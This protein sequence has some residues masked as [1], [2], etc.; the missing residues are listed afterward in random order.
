MADKIIKLVENDL[1]MQDFEAS[2]GEFPAEL[3]EPNKPQKIT[4]NTPIT[5]DSLIELG[6]TRI[7]EYVFVK[8]LL[9]IEIFNGDGAV[10]F[11]GIVINTIQESSVEHIKNILN[12]QTMP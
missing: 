9:K 8:N 10:W 7:G 4:S 12:N 1:Y 3:F 6:F 2:G 11:G 5:V